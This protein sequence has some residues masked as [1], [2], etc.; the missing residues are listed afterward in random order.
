MHQFFR[1]CVSSS[2]CPQK[3][4]DQQ[5]VVYFRLSVIVAEILIYLVK[6]IEIINNRKVVPYLFRLSFSIVLLISSPFFDS[7]FLLLNCFAGLLNWWSIVSYYITLILFKPVDM[8]GYLQSFFVVLLTSFAEDLLNGDGFSYFLLLWTCCYTRLSSLALVSRLF[9]YHLLP[10]K[11]W[12][13]FIN[14]NCLPVL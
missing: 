1:G 11:I 2:L 8:Q 4:I 5:L 13:W 9:F 3:K 14:N 12:W 10:L 6:D 7:F